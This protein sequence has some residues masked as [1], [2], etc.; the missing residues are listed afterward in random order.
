LQSDPIR[1]AWAAYQAHEK[2]VP[3]Q[4]RLDE[5]LHL[6]SSEEPARLHNDR[7]G[8]CYGENSRAPGEKHEAHQARSNVIP[9]EGSQNVQAV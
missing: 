3:V 2:R 9:T 7:D 4:L 8:E 5:E 1:R 6:T